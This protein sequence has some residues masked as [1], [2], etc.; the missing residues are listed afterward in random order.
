[1]RSRA[2]FPTLQKAFLR[3]HPPGLVN[4]LW[5]H[6]EATCERC[7][8]KTPAHERPDCEV[9]LIERLLLEQELD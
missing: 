7:G 8:C 1:M 9:R 2:I 4:A 3:D 6:F 5:A